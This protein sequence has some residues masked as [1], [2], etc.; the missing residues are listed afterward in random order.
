MTLAALDYETK[1]TYTV[2]VTA[3]DPD[4][5]SDAISVTITVTNEDEAGTVTFSGAPQVGVVLTA[6]LM[7]LDGNESGMEWQWAR[8]D[9]AGGDFVDIAGETS[10]AYTPVAEDEGK[11]LRATVAYADG[12]GADG[13][14]GE[15]SAAVSA[16]VRT[17]DEIRLEIEEAI[18]AAVLP[19]GIDDAERS[20]I[21]Q[22]ILEFALTPSS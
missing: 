20:A 2:T 16:D 17:R 18:L 19:D 21:E 1:D 9:G 15:T 13:A 14:M 12:A 22:L 7:D 5:E 10:A 8:D 11:L 4:G 6:S 3:T